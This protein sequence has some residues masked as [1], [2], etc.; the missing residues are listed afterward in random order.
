MTEP[1]SL[2]TELEDAVSRG[3][4]ESCLQALWHATDILIAG[5]YSED[6]IWTFGEIIGRLAEEIE[7][8]ARIRLADMLAPSTN[9]PLRVIKRLASDGSIAVAGPVIRPSE[10]RHCTTL[11][12][13][14]RTTGEQ[15][16]RPTPVPKSPPAPEPL[17]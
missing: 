12:S 1:K 15:P 3:T 6:Q 2:L 14:P 9:A 16:Q 11:T 5:R 4:A 7:I 17:T 8:G 10:R 13:C